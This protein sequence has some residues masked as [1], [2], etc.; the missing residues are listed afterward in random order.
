LHALSF[1]LITV[2]SVQEIVLIEILVVEVVH[3][4][5]ISTSVL[6]ENSLLLIFVGVLP[7]VVIIEVLMKFCV[8]LQMLNIND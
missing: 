4:W 3:T 5:R 8:H 2:I 6:T 1:G 7:V